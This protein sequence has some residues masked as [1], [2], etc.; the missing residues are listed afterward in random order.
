MRPFFE[1]HVANANHAKV[2]T[3]VIVDQ[4][5]FQASNLGRFAT[6]CQSVCAVFR[7]RKKRRQKANRM[8]TSLGNGEGLSFV[9]SQFLEAAVWTYESHPVHSEGRQD[10]D[11][12][13][14]THLWGVWRDLTP[15]CIFLQALLS[16]SSGNASA[17]WAA[18]RL[19]HRYIPY[20]DGRLFQ[21]SN[22]ALPPM[23]WRL[24]TKG[25]CMTSCHGR[26]FAFRSDLGKLKTKTMPS[27]LFIEQHR[28]LSL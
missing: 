18:H 7:R 2:Q 14:A 17:W 22:A 12:R 19:S 25:C 5:A 4:E 24:T 23:C 20:T 13:T 6:T 21:C 11:P 28:D 27:L 9:F 8:S 16:G 10:L 15:S 26:A 1:R 3:A